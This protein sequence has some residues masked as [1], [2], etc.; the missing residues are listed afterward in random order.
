MLVRTHGGATLVQIVARGNHHPAQT[1]PQ[2]VD[3]LGAWFRRRCGDTLVDLGCDMS[4]PVWPVLTVVLHPCAQ[5]LRVHSGRDRALT[6][7]VCTSA[8]GA[9]FH[10]YAC[11][12]L[13]GMAEDLEISWLP[14]DPLGGTGSM[15]ETGYLFSRDPAGIEPAMLDWLAGQAQRI[16]DA[17]DQ[18]ACLNLPLDRRFTC[19]GVATPMG[20]RPLAWVGRAAAAP[21]E[22]TDVFPWHQPGLG[23]EQLLGR[24][25]TQMWTD[26]RWRVPVSDSEALTTLRICNMLASAHRA[27]P[28][29]DYPWAEWRELVDLVRRAG[30]APDLPGDLAALVEQLGSGRPT[31]GY[32]R[33][34]VTVVLPRG[35]EVT[36]PGDF[37]EDPITD[38]Q[39]WRGWD[40]HRR[41][42]IDTG[43]FAEAVDP[44]AAYRRFLPNHLPWVSHQTAKVTGRAAFLTETRDSGTTTFL[45]GVMLADEAGPDCAVS[46]LELDNPSERSWALDVW[47]SIDRGPR[48]AQT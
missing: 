25:L 22:G 48:S 19:E 43:T 40:R 4:D 14:Y 24:A 7:A 9:G 47:R 41:L 13:H 39:T 37:A 26:V 6:A 31:I 17:G 44:N 30:Y 27:D 45:V 29:M 3:D 36:V 12:V 18:H 16:V 10:R 42:S 1:W 33:R 21:T 46:T 11:D 2:V 15:D 23:P 28:G 38:G 8:V 32:R 20:P 35:W 34:P 5:A